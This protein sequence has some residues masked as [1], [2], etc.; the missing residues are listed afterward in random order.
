[1]SDS[2]LNAALRQFE[3]V[4]ANLVK[5]ERALAEARELI[6]QG[7][8]FG[9]NPAYDR[10]RWTIDE[11]LDALPAIDGWRPEVALPDLNE[12]AQRRLDS[13]EIMEPGILI[14]L[15]EELDEPS[16]SIGEYRYKFDK[17]RRELVRAAIMDLVEVV[18]KDVDAVR[19]SV[20]LTGNETQTVD[21]P[22]FERLRDHIA[23]IR[24]LL[25]GSAVPPP[26]WGDLHR[27]L[28]FG[29]VCDVR[30][31]LDLDWPATRAGL[32]RSLYE[33]LEPVPVEAA[34]LGDLV[35]ARPSGPVATSL[36]WADLSDEDYERL[37]FTLITAEAGYENA[38]WLTR[39]N[40]PDGGRDL[41]V[42]RVSFDS[43]AGTQRQRVIIQCKHWTTKSISP[44]EVATLKEQMRLHEPPRVD[45]CVI[46]TS[47]RFTA[48][49]IRLIESHNAS[50]SGLRIEMWPDSHFEML[51]A[52]RPW[53][54]A[55]F[56]LR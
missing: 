19:G 35:G 42:D 53:L 34:D 47:G 44:T 54:I 55:E 56:G 12:V 22:E 15:Y 50:D 40:A 5:L 23:Q 3:A 18:D 11:L 1:M 43:L 49:A 9:E 7:I 24:V 29:L 21:A 37:V 16:R 46:A 13:E 6:P 45:V 41:S 32:H 2:D 26:R 17:K 25:G 10:A 27:H 36:K 33:E 28:S 51:L 38:Q 4:E 39:T 8:A 31:I 20:D 48:D 30:D 52:T 14:S